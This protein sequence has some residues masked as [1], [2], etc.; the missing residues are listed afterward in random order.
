MGISRDVPELFLERRIPSGLVRLSAF[1]IP[2]QPRYGQKIGLIEVLGTVHRAN[3]VAGTRSE[4][5][6]H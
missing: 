5:T 2:S 3:V 1:S 6:D 4:A